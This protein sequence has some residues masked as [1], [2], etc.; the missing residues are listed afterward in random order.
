[1]IESK[2]V[3]SAIYLCL[4]VIV[5]FSPY[6]TLMRP[7]FGRATG[8][9]PQQASLSDTRSQAVFVMIVAGSIGFLVFL[10]VFKESCCQS[11]AQF[12]L[13]YCLLQSAG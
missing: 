5:V 3:V 8:Q 13:P 6:I 11:F 7:A 9:G 4:V 1:M 2:A 10:E 12:R